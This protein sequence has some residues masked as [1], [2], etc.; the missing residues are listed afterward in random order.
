MK[1]LLSAIVVLVGATASA[2][3]QQYT[4]FPAP[5]PFYPVERS[6]LTGRAVI[7]P[8]YAQPFPVRVYSTPPQQPYY[9]VPPYAVV[10]PY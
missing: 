3:V 5:T 1:L 8:P 2:E 9:N 7:I 4:E 10:A 6:T